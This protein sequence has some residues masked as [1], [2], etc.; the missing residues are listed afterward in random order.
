MFS[1]YK[2]NFN[3]YVQCLL[4]YTSTHL[5]PEKVLC[6]KWQQLKASPDSIQR[7]NEML[8]V[9]ATRFKGCHKYRQIKLDIDET[10]PPRVQAPRKIPFAKREKLEEVLKE[11]S[12]ED[13][14]EEVT[15]P[16]EWISNLVLTPKDD[17]TLRMNID[18]TMANPAIKSTCHVI[19]MI[20]ELKYV[21]NGAQV[22][23]KLD[24]HQGYMQFQ[25]HPESRHMTVFYTHQGLR[26]MNRLNFGK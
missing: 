1:L 26:R 3:L 21:L 12:E 6:E 23:S 14:I 22:F 4:F 20:E 8:E 10:V 13:I 2:L 24:M 15:G 25:L 18:M 17:K 5:T 16:T 11:L 9:Y 7:V 19:P